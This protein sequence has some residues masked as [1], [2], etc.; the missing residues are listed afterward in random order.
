MAETLTPIVEQQSEAAAL[1]ELIDRLDPTSRTFFA[2]AALGRDALEFVSSDLGK[3]MIGCAKQDVEDAH[4]K[5]KTTIPWR[6]RRIQQLQN[7]I[8]C[9]EQFV[10]YLR[11]L[12]IRG[13][14]A[15]VALDERDES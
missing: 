4:Q 13:K 9:A 2:E 10:L 12:I 14:A 3:Y 7:E 5:L 1:Q 6:R 8:R 11:D 15:E